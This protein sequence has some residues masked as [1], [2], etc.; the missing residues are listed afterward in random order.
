MK[1]REQ[2]V[3]ELAKSVGFDLV[4]ISK[5]KNS[6]ITSNRFQKWLDNN[7]HASMKWISKRKEERKDIFKYFPEVKSI[8][9]FGFNYYTNNYYTK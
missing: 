5:P 1:T 8:I 3:V 6:N 7:N 2:I 4:G 9:S